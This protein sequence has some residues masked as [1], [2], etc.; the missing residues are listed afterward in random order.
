MA[1]CSLSGSSSKKPLRPCES[2]ILVNLAP[3]RCLRHLLN[4][5]RPTEA[6][7]VWEWYDCS[8]P[9]IAREM[10]ETAR[11]RMPW[12]C[13]SKKH[14]PPYFSNC[15]ARVE[16]SS[17]LVCKRTAPMASLVQSFLT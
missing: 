16:F 12:V 13:R 11:R 7:P 2:A 14:G 15:L 5:H 10:H 9:D 4:A 8:A 1:A 17:D 3:I 6:S